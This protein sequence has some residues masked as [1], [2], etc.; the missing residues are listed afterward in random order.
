MKLAHII[1]AKS[2]TK[3]FRQDVEMYLAHVILEYPQYYEKIKWDTDPKDRIKIID[4]SAYELV[5][6]KHGEALPMK[7]V[8]KAA[9]VVWGTEIVLRD[10]PG[11]L[12]KSIQLT[13]N[14]LEELLDLGW[15][16]DIMAVVQG[17]TIEEWE[18]YAEFLNEIPQVTTIG[19]PKYVNDMGRLPMSGR[20]ELVNKLYTRSSVSK[21]IHLLGTTYGIVEFIGMNNPMV[22]SCDTSYFVTESQKG[23]P[24]TRVRQPGEE[25]TD[26]I[27]AVDIDKVIAYAHKVD[28]W[29]GA[30]VT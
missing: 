8:V 20:T 5:Y 17:A 18:Y 26:L 28:K 9:N 27:E 30:L 23:S 11:D 15:K 13:V 10:A 19:I 29:I 3:K 4:N 12:K 14:S 22:R 2:T 25:S 7:D 1:P 21:P 16:H 6:L 24:I